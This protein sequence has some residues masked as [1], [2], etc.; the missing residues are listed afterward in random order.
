MVT[1][2]K[3]LLKIFQ[4]EAEDEGI[5]QAEL[6]RVTEAHP[7]E[8]FCEAG[9]KLFQIRNCQYGDSFVQDGLPGTLA[10]LSGTSERLRRLVTNRSSSNLW[11]IAN[12]LMD[13]HNY[14][15][16]SL[17]LVEQ[18]LQKLEEENDSNPITR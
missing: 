16:M 7:V 15:I 12:I 1:L 9:I 3:Q 18:E 14:A 8:I 4:R 6:Q 5:S 13:I 11:R 17:W 10:I 2:S